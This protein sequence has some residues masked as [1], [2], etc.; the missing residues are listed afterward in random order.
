MARRLIVTLLFFAACSTNDKVPTGPTLTPSVSAIEPST[1]FLGRTLDVHLVGFDT[2]WTDQ[3]KVSFGDGVTVN[4]VTAASATGLTCNVTI[5]ASAKQGARDVTVMDGANNELF[6]STFTVAAPI[7]V[8]FQGT[9][10]Q[11]SVS[12]LHVE[13]VDFAS[14]FD[15][16]SVSGGFGP[17]T[18]T[19]ISFKLPAG[20]NA[21]VDS[22]TPTTI[23]AVLLVDVDAAAAAGDIEVVSGP[24]AGNQVHN[25]LPSGLN[26]K[27]RTATAL[28]AGMTSGTESTAFDSQLYTFAPGAATLS[29]NQ[30]LVTAPNTGMPAPGPQ[31]TLLPK[32]GH[33]VDLIGTPDVTQ[34]F[35]TTSTDP[36]YVIIWDNTGAS[37][38]SYSLLHDGG[39]VTG[40]DSNETMNDTAAGQPLAT[41]PALV[42]KGNFDPMADATDTFSFTVAAAD[43]NKKAHI[44]TFGAAGPTMAVD[45]TSG[46]QT[47][48]GAQDVG[49]FV[50]FTTNALPAGTYKIRVSPSTMSPFGAQGGPY[51]LWLRLE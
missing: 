30:L 32:S 4:K 42:Q 45:V 15:S 1:V 49:G 27:A 25:P 47:S 20:V 2:A 39:A 21:N 36:F 22:V 13:L 23:E 7:R 48:V 51:S 35:T 50:D 16:T 43:A 12:I 19:N 24:A 37:G 14:L 40:V 11:G 41:L 34:V 28:P 46:P 38:Y 18:F 10:A 5:A 9:V 17:P 3:T 31:I 29:V 44:V 33:F 6:H 26:I 8:S